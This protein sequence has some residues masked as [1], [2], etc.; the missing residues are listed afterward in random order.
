MS[1]KILRKELIKLAHANKDLRPHL[2]P[3]I[4]ASVPKAAGCEKLPEGP[5]RDNCEKSKEDGEVGKKEAGCEKLPE[6]PMRDN[7]Q[8]SKEDG[9]VGGKPKGKKDDKPKGD[10]KK[11]D[12]KMPADLLEKFK[13]KKAKEMR[14]AELRAAA[15]KKASDDP[16][17]YVALKVGKY[18]VE[19]AAI[20]IDD[21]MIQ[22]TEAY[23]K[24]AAEKTG[25]QIIDEH[26]RNVPV[27]SRDWGYMGFT[28]EEDDSRYLKDAV[29]AITKEAKKISW[30][31]KVLVGPQWP[32]SN[33]VIRSA[34]AIPKSIT[35]LPAKEQKVA[36][37]MKKKGY[38]YC[39][40]IVAN[41]KNF[42]EPLYFKG[43][44]KVG[45]F[46]RSFPDSAKAK[47]AWS[48]TL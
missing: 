30:V 7:C 25:G 1:D 37:G 44:D 26:P 45:P 20:G 3:I 4:E 15:G 19:V 11:D 34:A 18:S 46:L 13:K 6:G 22:S 2:M 32:K 24:H 35:D 43:A 21:R 42:G 10:A 28:V 40:Q 29:K 41:G 23:L 36:E 8:K 38:L 16:D 12:G 48:F 31:G 17:L 33:A 27:P 39:V 5:M 9:A 47:T 14:L